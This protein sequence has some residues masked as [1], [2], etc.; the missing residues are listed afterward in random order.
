L[1]F[2]QQ[3]VTPQFGGTF[4]RPRRSCLVMYL[5]IRKSRQTRGKA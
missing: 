5:A 2:T 1:G 4:G 3:I